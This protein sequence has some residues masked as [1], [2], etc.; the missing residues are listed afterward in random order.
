MITGIEFNSLTCF[1]QN[2]YVPIL[3]SMCM[4]LPDFICR[5]IRGHVCV[6][7]SPDKTDCVFGYGRMNIRQP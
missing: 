5:A 6:T 4:P 3:A 1:S 2:M 7:K